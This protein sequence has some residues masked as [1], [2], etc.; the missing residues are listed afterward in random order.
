VPRIL[1]R[2]RAVPAAIV[3]V[4]LALP[5]LYA[6]SARAGTYDVT[7]C[8]SDGSASGW[9][10]YGSSSYQSG[11]VCPYNGDLTS[12]GLGV[13][14][15]PNVG[16]LGYSGGG[17]MFK[18]PAGTTLAGIGS[19][20]RIQRWDA[21]YWLGLFSASGQ[22]LFGFVANDGNGAPAGAYTARS[23]FNMNREAN[24]HLEVGCSALCDTS[25]L[26]GSGF[27]A[28]AQLF[29]PITVRI[30]DD[31]APSEAVTGGG[32]VAGP[33][34]TGAQ[35][36]TY[37]ASDASGIRATR[38]YVDGSRLRD[39]MRTCNFEQP[40]PCSNV[41]AGS[42]SVDT[43]SLG[44]GAHTV[45]VETVD[46]AGNASSQSRSI[47]VD[48]SAPAAPTVSVSGGEGWRR[49]ND[50][51][52]T[53]SNPAGQ[54][55]PIAK[56]HFEVCRADQPANCQPTGLQTGANISTISGLSVPGEGDYTVRVWLEDAA[57]NTSAA[58]S[59][60]PIHLR[61]DATAPVSV[62]NLTLANGESWRSTNSFD[63]SWENPSGQLA[64]ITS[65]HY[66]MCDN[67]GNCA[68]E[69]R[70]GG[71]EMD[72]VAGV[73]VPGPGDYTLS[74]WMG[75]DAGN[76]DEA[77]A[78]APVHLR[79]DDND[80]G[81]AE[82]AP[83]EGWLGAADVAGGYD[84][85]I[86]VDPAQ[87]DALSGLA[88]FAVSLDGS[89]PGTSP[90]VGPDGLLHIAELGEGR[91]TVKA[92]A[93]SGS[94]VASGQV[95]TTVLSVDKSAPAVS[96]SGAPDPD[97]WEPQAVTVKLRASDQ[98]GLSGMSGGRLIY[99]VDGSAAQS[100]E[101][102]SADVPVAG[103]GRH[104]ITYSAADLAGNASS[105]KSVSFKLD[106]TPP[107]DAALSDP[108]RWLNAVDASE[109]V[110][111][112]GLANGASAPLSGLAGYS[113]T[114]DGSAP[115]ASPE[116]SAEPLEL[117]RLAEGTTVV[118]ARA[119]SGSGLASVNSGSVDLHVDRTPPEVS[120]AGAPDPESWQGGPVR[121]ELKASDALSGMSQGS[122]V[123]AIDDRAE[124]SVEGDSVSVVVDGDGPHRI[125]YYAID[126]A[127]NRTDPETAR[128]RV[129]GSKPGAAVPASSDGWINPS[130]SYIE[131]IELA[132]GE[133]S[134]PSGLAGF[135][136][137]TD[138]T[139]PDGSPETGADGSFPIAQLGEGVTTVKARAVSGAGV[140][141]DSVGVGTIKVDR[142]PPAAVLQRP[143][144]GRLTAHVSDALSGVRSGL[145]EIRGA[146]GG[147]WTTLDT[148]LG[149][150]TMTALLDA[151]RLEEGRYDLRATALDAAGNRRVVTT[152]ADG[153]A[154]TVTLGGGESAVPQPPSAVPPAAP[155][156]AAPPTAP[157]RCSTKP[158]R[159]KRGHHHRPHRTKHH[160]R[161][162]TN[163]HQRS[164]GRRVKPT[165]QGGEKHRHRH[166]GR[167]THKRARRSAG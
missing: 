124:N 139:T 32:L 62:R 7:S 45:K 21:S 146:D 86:A 12:R 42:Y 34:A 114:T 37:N 130:G 144:G 22:N 56:A 155:R 96:V 92:R 115:D 23:W 158:K 49:S 36:V 97:V 127:G 134:P 54:V 74:L 82:P 131:Q 26:P 90:D 160:R 61:Y 70:D 65:V 142:T 25:S 84:E 69:T 113:F 103:D 3:A 150:G 55:A 157:V 80:P 95:G 98:A 31:D 35:P 60:A 167:K 11:I 14:N 141:S 140:A 38:L 53:W 112:V 81:R 148:R 73:R 143:D 132:D 119:V 121:L 27:R 57:G 44:D 102:D 108:G 162:H 87:L 10:A 99:S 117:G 5:C 91:V 154:G 75:D 47:S 85:R 125:T 64:P 151:G 163:H 123:Y 43:R 111:N 71:A 138:G 145:F 104:T 164:R 133:A 149:D 33:Y 15:F 93:I 101:G 156:P 136:V 51:T 83:H 166:L 94:G 50:F 48:N 152:F 110:Q 1:A 129:D 159:A 137:T 20:V 41:S 58:S 24:V 52:L 147:S 126:S 118:K 72:S 19:G 28:W 13:A 116:T 8:N 30:E 68:T 2:R 18:A 16:V 79:F 153:G 109:Y 39:D 67:Q 135:S 6:G 120:L 63:V 161:H 88:G 4:A 66:R 9:A 128:L 106:T 59:S 105:E 89:D 76:A 17:L 40:V 107:A 122:V 78:T 165:C 100:V 46:S 29:D 77:S